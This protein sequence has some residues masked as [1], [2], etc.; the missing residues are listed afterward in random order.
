MCSKHHFGASGEPSSSINTFLYVP[1]CDF[2]TVMAKASSTA[3][4][5]Y[6]SLT[7]RF[8]SSSFMCSLSLFW[9]IKPIGIMMFR[10]KVLPSA[11]ECPC[12]QVFCRRANHVRPATD[13]SSLAGRRWW[14]AASRQH[15]CSVSPRRSA[16]LLSHGSACHPT[17]AKS[18]C[19]PYHWLLR[20]PRCHCC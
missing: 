12:V 19:T 1:P 6:A 13:L 20:N 11:S 5:R 8:P 17:P 16:A 2:H 9:F 18:S 4:W 3:C 15:R 14:T 10:L 7:D